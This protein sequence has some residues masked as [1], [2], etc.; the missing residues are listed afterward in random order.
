[1]LRSSAE[2]RASR[3]LFGLPVPWV[4]LLGVRPS[5]RRSLL[6]VRAAI[7]FARFSGMP[8]STELSLMCSYWRS[9]LLLQA[10]GMRFLL[11]CSDGDELPLPHLDLEE[12]VG[13][14]VRVGVPQELDGYV[15][16]RDA[17]R[18]LPFRPAAMGMAV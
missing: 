1:M 5:S 12:P 15:V 3:P 2:V 4:V 9:S 8:R 14:K 13:R 6:T 18:G 17:G 10:G 16:D 11:S 7:S